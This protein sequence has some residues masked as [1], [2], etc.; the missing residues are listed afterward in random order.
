MDF[1][2]RTG[3][4]HSFT[5]CSMDPYPKMSLGWDPARMTGLHCAANFHKTIQMAIFML[6]EW[7]LK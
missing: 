7:S 5:N 6:V 2:S 4:G 3:G 1:D